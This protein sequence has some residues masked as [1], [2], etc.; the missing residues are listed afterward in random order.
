MTDEALMKKV[1][2]DLRKD[3]QRPVSLTEAVRAA[4]SAAKPGIREEAQAEVLEA[5]ERYW[6]RS[7]VQND[8]AQ[9]LKDDILEGIQQELG[10]SSTGIA[11]T[12]TEE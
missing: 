6:A 1:I 7:C 12:T 10:A 4:I 8:T 11:V 3:G 2:A 9:G 5:F